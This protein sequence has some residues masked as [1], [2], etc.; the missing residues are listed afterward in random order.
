MSNHWKKKNLQVNILYTIIISCFIIGI[1][2]DF[3][4]KQSLSYD[5][6]LSCLSNAFV[7]LG[8]LLLLVHHY[9]NTKWRL[10]FYLIFI[11]TTLTCT[12]FI[13]NLHSFITLKQ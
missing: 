12:M 6:L 4:L 5:L 2:I 7:F 3:F 13:I 11:M 10:G 8:F 1:S 9:K